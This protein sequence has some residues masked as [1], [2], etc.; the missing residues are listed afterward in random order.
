[1]PRSLSVTLRTL[2]CGWRP[3]QPLCWFSCH[4]F[5][6]AG[7]TS[8]NTNCLFS[9][10]IISL[11]VAFGYPMIGRFTI[12]L[13]LPI[14]STGPALTFSFLTSTQRVPRSA[15]GG[16]CHLAPRSLAVLAL[17]ESCVDLGKGDS[18]PC[19]FLLAGLVIVD[20]AALGLTMPHPALVYCLT[21]PRLIPSRRR[22][23]P[24]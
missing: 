10:L 15:G 7:R 2:Q 4:T 8:A 12:M 22:P 13:L 3:S 6:I 18:A 23:P 14:W 21:S 5:H 20:P 17:L 9:K 19:P 11:P 16:M 24:S 1:M